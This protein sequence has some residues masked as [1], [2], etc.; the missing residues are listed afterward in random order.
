[1]IRHL[2]ETNGHVGQQA[3]LAIVRQ[4]FWPIGARQLTRDVTRSCIRCIKC[5]PRPAEQFMGDLPSYRVN[6]I[7]TFTNTGIDYAGP[8]TLKLT[9]RTNIKT[10]YP[11]HITQR[12]DHHH[13][14]QRPRVRT[15]TP[16]VDKVDIWMLA[17]IKNDNQ[18]PSNWLLGR[19]MEL[20]PGKDDIDRVVSLRTKQGTIKRPIVNVCPL[21]ISNQDEDFVEDNSSTPPGM[22][23]TRPPK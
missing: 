5:N 7:H 18:P 22:L 20:Y 11:L 17:I 3:L 14:I 10:C 9:R 15:C 2:H 16:L 1:L 8:I 4:R 23:A 21:P 12:F 13:S 19:I 6:T